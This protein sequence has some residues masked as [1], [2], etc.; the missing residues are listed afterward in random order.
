VRSV[1]L[2][3]WFQAGQLPQIAIGIMVS[4]LGSAIRE[5]ERYLTHVRACEG[6]KYCTC[7]VDSARDKLWRVLSEHFKQLEQMNEAVRKQMGGGIER[8]G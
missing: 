2:V 4:E 8:G 3:A 6:P 1:R 5:L 7:E